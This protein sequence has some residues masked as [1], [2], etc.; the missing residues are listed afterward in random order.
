MN[1]DCL[2]IIWGPYYRLHVRSF[3]H[4]SYE[5]R[6]TLWIG[7]LRLWAPLKGFEVVIK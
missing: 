5:L 1:R 3:D 7:C 6:S 4:S 2:R